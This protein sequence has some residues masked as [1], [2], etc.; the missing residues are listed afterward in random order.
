MTARI[1]HGAIYI[2]VF[3][4]LYFILSLYLVNFTQSTQSWVA[5]DYELVRV[6]V[7]AMNNNRS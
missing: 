7:K 5:K 1:R 3:Y 6:K 2:F 4:K